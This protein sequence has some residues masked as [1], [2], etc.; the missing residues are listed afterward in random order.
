MDAP[1]SPNHMIDFP[2]NEPALELED[3]VME[4]DEDPMEDPDEDSNMD[5]DENEEDD[6]Y[7]VGGAS[8]AVPEAPYLVGHPL[9]II[10]ARVSL[11]HEDI[12]A[13]CVRADKMEYMQTSLLRKG[14]VGLRRWFEKVEQVFEISKCAEEDKVKFVVCTFEGRALTWWN[15]NVHTLGLVN[16]NS[17]PWNEF[18]AMMT[19][20]YCPATEIQ[21]IEQELWTLTLKGDD[22]EGYNNRFHELALMFHELMTPEKKKIKRYIRGLPE[23][24]KAN[25]SSSKPT[26]LHDAIN[27]AR[28]LVEQAIQAKSTRIRESNKR[29]WEEHQGSNNNCNHNIHHQQQNMRQEGAKAYTAAP[30]ELKGYLGTRPLYNQR[31]LNHDGQCPPKCKICK[32]IGHQTRD[33]WSKTHAVNKPPTPN[34]NA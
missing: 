8:S 15:E 14:V 4:V 27:M 1:P 2:A 17:I 24:I 7:E 33:C 32:R 13:L 20:E 28:E 18:K 30:A 6:F 31:N 23:R 22:I 34:D 11:H 19:T 25:V 10:A 29:R 26:N 5:I 16:A 3:P 9:P 12:G 21:R